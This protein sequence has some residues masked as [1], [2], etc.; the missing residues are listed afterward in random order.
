MQRSQPDTFKAPYPA[1]QAHPGTD[2]PDYVAGLI[3][4]QSRNGADPSQILERVDAILGASAVGLPGHVEQASFTDTA[5]AVNRVFLPYWKTAD[6]QRAF[7]ER[8]DFVEL[9]TKPLDGDVGVCAECFSAP[10]FKLDG[11]YAIKNIAYGI[12]R[13]SDI[14]DEQFHAY[15]GS[16]RDRV[17][18]FLSGES[19]AEPG[20]LQRRNNGPETLGRALTVTDL[21]HNLCYIRNVV[22]WKE[23]NEEE[24]AVYR[25]DMLPVYQ[26]GAI[27]LRDNPEESNCI[28][29]RVA[30]VVDTGVDYGV[31]SNAIAWFLTLK[32][33]ERWVR[34]HP[35]HLAIMRTIMNY[36]EQFNFQPKLNLGHEVIV[37]PKG[38]VRAWYNNCHGDTGFLPFFAAE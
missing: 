36:M 14:K 17:P 38:G 10:T 26:E 31:Q 7:V 13:Y 21:P 33:L 3:I 8:G 6:A 23:A 25:R 29:M 37:V 12:G 9:V 35:R 30:D 2:R 20:A 27:Y 15:M 18:G 11:A 32:D 19:D 22:A 4:V 16:M 1:Y 24:Q 28:A 5:G 34:T